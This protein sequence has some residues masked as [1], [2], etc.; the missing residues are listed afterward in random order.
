MNA[1]W[2]GYAVRAMSCDG[3]TAGTR[4]LIRLNAS[5]SSTLSQQAGHWWNSRS[6][7]G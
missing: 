4:A 7:I 2:P 5:R 1:H 3:A 6:G